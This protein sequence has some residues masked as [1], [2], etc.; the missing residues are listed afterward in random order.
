MAPIKSCVTSIQSV[1]FH[2]WNRASVSKANK[3]RHVTILRNK[4]KQNPCVCLRYPWV[5]SQNCEKPLFASFLSLRIEKFRS[6]WTDLY[7]IRLRKPD[8]PPKFGTFV[9]QNKLRNALQCCHSCSEVRRSASSNYSIF[10]KYFFFHFF[11]RFTRTLKKGHVVVGC[12]LRI[13]VTRNIP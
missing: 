11:E 1:S 4:N 7:E 13:T 3:L 8:P 2:I 6:H 12:C 10:R 9:F 5:H